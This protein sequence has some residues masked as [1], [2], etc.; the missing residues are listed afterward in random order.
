MVAGNM[1]ME[2]SLG[3]VT[4]MGSGEDI[5]ATRAEAVCSTAVVAAVITEAGC[6][7]DMVSLYSGAS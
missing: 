2:K 5:T 4:D 6:I 7:T 3:W 1:V